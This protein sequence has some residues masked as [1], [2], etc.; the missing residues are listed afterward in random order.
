M[1]G[2]VTGTVTHAT[3]ARVRVRYTA[4]G[5]GEVETGYISY[6]SVDLAGG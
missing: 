4:E 1:H 5:G 3:D 6:N 2:G